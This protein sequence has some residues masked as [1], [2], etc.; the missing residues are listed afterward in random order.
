MAERILE[1]AA[2]LGIP[3]EDV[4]IDPLVLT[5]GSD[6]KAALV[7]L[8]TVELLRKEFG[9]N[10]NL[11]ASNV[12]FGLPE[13]LTVNAAFLTLGIQCGATCAITDPAK[14]GQTVRAADLL[15]GRDDYSMRY[16][17]YF[18]AAGALRAKEAEQAA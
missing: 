11:G 6:S 15:L 10:I 9:V 14:L 8:Q 16:L 17:K 7:T 1:R 4:I 12:S 3:A 5:V 2:K 13:R 18:R